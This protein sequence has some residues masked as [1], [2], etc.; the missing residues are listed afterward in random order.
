MKRPS[1]WLFVLAC[2]SSASPAFSADGYQRVAGL[3]VIHY[4][5]GLTIDATDSVVTGETGILVSFTQ[6]GVTRIPF[7]LGI[8][9]VDEVTVNTT[10]AVF[11]HDQKKLTVTLPEAYP[12]GTRGTVT[13]KY[14]GQP[15]D[16]LFIMKNKFGDRT[17]FADNFSNRAHHWFPG[18]DHPYDKATAEFIITAP[19]AY[20]VIAPGRLMERTHLKNGT[21]RTHWRTKT[22]IPTYCMVIGAT[23]FSVIQAGSWNGIPV[24][25]YLY[26]EDRENG[27]TD[28]ER[29][30]RMLEFYTKLIGPYPYSKLALV[31]STTRYGG[32]EN[33][34]AI[35]FSE[36]SIRGTK[37]GE[38]TVAHEIAHQ[39]FGDSVTETDWHDVWLS[40]GFATYFGAL[41][42]ERDEGRDRFMEMMTRNKDRYLRTF[43]S[44][45]GPIH[46]PRK[47]DLSDVLTSFHYVKGAWVLHML[48]GIMGD[49]AFFAGIRDYYRTY[50]DR[51]ATT[52]DLQRVMAFHA[53]QPLGWFFQQWIY[54]PG[55]PIY[56]LDWTWNAQAK[57]A[58]VRIRQTQAGTVY[59]MPLNLAFYTGD[60]VVRKKIQSNGKEQRVTISLEAEPERVVLDPDGWILKEMK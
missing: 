57:Q 16:G 55:H 12:S 13:I 20:D 37:Q 54:E 27:I 49:N 32:M 28:F 30:L 31:E 14:H 5:I 46:D 7:D 24:S 38:G 60:T 18:I 50:R 34:S 59:E 53:G 45:P 1:L 58:E 33:A 56:A 19:E 9:M 51:N 23:Q 44:T 21:R 52:D 22:E 26:P 11:T 17:I 36:R 4:R 8:M 47:T 15:R 25:Y 48:R 3:D 39:W 41:F 29:S 40:E 2:C 6:D 10:K 35:F 43:A 42:F